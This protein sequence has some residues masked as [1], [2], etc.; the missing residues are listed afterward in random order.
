MRG[1]APSR[2]EFRAVRPLM[3]LQQEPRARRLESV[4]S[5]FYAGAPD[6]QDLETAVLRDLAWLVA[7][8]DDVGE[9][10][11]RLGPARDEL[12]KF[13]N[14]KAPDATRQW[15][16][17][18]PWTEPLRHAYLVRAKDPRVQDLVHL[19]APLFQLGG[20]LFHPTDESELRHL[21]APQ[22]FAEEIDWACVEIPDFEDSLLPIRTLVM[23]AQEA[24]DPAPGA[25]TANR[26][27]SG[28]QD[29]SD[30][31]QNT[32]TPTHQTGELRPERLGQAETEKLRPER[33]GQTR[34]EKL[35]PERLGQPLTAKEVEVRA[36]QLM[37]GWTVAEG[38][39]RLVMER[40]FPSV[41]AA[42]GFVI[43]VVEIGTAVGYVPEISLNDQVVE[44][45]L[46]SSAEDELTD[47]D[48]DLARRIQPA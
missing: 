38:G 45:G 4:A 23:A 19:I 47:F 40:R 25:D 9:E 24:D 6:L 31:T 2:N 3:A 36:A 39:D 26:Q 7:F 8:L 21:I 14:R 35:R 37:G 46:S 43:Q 32:D 16:E 34:T 27:P 10:A 44:V 20:V 28:D 42:A 12:L 17:H 48:F 13:L 18:D 30:E 11:G 1:L 41:L 33:L 22:V 15:M 5:V 29:M